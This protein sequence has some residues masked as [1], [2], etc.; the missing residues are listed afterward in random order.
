MDGTEYYV[1]QVV[2]AVLREVD[3]EPSK[4]VISVNAAPRCRARA[5]SWRDRNEKTHL[6]QMAFMWQFIGQV[7]TVMD[8]W[9]LKLH[10]SVGQVILFPYFD[11]THVTHLPVTYFS[12]ISWWSSFRG[13]NFFSLMHRFTSDSMWFRWRHVSSVCAAACERNLE[14]ASL[15]FFSVGVCGEGEQKL[16]LIAGDFIVLLKGLTFA[17]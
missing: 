8:K 15:N 3:A 12:E 1:E 2:F 4:A 11:H 5:A 7:M 16:Q 17:K 6:G 9:I 10:L 14:K 13:Q